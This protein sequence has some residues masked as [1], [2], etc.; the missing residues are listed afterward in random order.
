MDKILRE[1]HSL[2]EVTLNQVEE[3]IKL[4]TFKRKVQLK[5]NAA[6][7]SHLAGQLRKTRD[8]ETAAASSCRLATPGVK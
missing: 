8:L 2:Q 6:G 5:T 4:W 3:V 7:N 1:I